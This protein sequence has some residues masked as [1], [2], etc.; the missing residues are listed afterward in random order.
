MF[1]F[2]WGKKGNAVDLHTV[3]INLFNDVSSSNFAFIKYKSRQYFL[4]FSFWKQLSVKW[5]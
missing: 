1:I 3:L 2:K 4:H 5:K